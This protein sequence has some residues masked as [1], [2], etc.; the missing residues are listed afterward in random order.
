MRA[1]V[2]IRMAAAG[3]AALAA[4]GLLSFIP[5]LHGQPGSVQD[6]TVFRSQSSGGLDQRNLVDR[7]SAMTFSKRL[8]RAEWTGSVLKIDLET[9][10]QNRSGTGWLEDLRQLAELSFVQAPNVSRLLVRLKAPDGSLLAAADLRRSDGWLSADTLRDW[11][12]IHPEQDELWRS[13]LRL[14]Y[15]SKWRQSEGESGGA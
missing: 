2:G 8:T 6:R 14:T 11:S 13:R 7:L 12:G 10:L 5:S 3:F 9:E 4:A 15:L 1:G